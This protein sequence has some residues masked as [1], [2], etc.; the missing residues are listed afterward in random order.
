MAINQSILLVKKT[1]YFTYISD[2]RYDERGIMLQSDISKEKSKKGIPHKQIQGS[3]D[4]NSIRWSWACRLLDPEVHYEIKADDKDSPPNAGDIGLFKVT[5]IGSHT[6]LI[7]VSSQKL[8]IYAGDL[9]TGVFGNRYATDAIEAEVDKVRNLSLIT[10]AGMV[11]TVRSKHSSIRRTTQVSFLGYLTSDDERINTKELV[12]AKSGRTTQLPDQQPNLVVIIGSGMNS[13]KTTFCRKLIKSFRRKGTKVA[14]CK[15]TGSISPRDFDEMVSASAIHVTDFSDYGFP[16]T[17]KCDREEILDLF[18]TMLADLEK[19]KPDIIIMEVADGVLQ[20]ETKMILSEPSFKELIRGVIVTADSA[21]ATLYTV[22]YLEQAGYNI[23]CVSGSIT[24]SPLYVEE[25]KDHHNVPVVSSKGG[26]IEINS[27][28][29]KLLKV[30]A[31]I[32]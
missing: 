3:E 8:R 9:F 12:F 26:T 31:R 2:D 14:A 11:G 28:F 1:I 18:K 23:L 22:N 17:Y 10:T 24:S 6:R 32:A 13:G 29:E 19:L 30:E 5:R 20:R 4:E 25:F 15:L 16:S 7:N 21:P 27:V